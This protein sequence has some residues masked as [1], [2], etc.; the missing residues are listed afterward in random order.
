MANCDSVAPSVALAAVDAVIVPPCARCVCRPDNVVSPAA[1]RL[2]AM[3]DRPTKVADG[4]AVRISCAC[5]TV[6]GVMIVTACT[7]AKFRCGPLPVITASKSAAVSV[8]WSTVA[9]TDDASTA[10]ICATC[11][12]VLV[13]VTVMALALA[14]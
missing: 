2:A 10:W 1:A 6:G 11:I 9:V 13:P 14:R 5:S 8:I 7:P 3:S 12:A 4:S